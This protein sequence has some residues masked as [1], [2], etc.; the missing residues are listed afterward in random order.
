MAS[1]NECSSDDGICGDLE[2]VSGI[3][4]DDQHFHVQAKTGLADEVAPCAYPAFSPDHL[5]HASMLLTA[6]EH[7]GVDSIDKLQI[8]AGTAKQ[9]QQ[10]VLQVFPSGSAEHDA[11]TRT[12]HDAFPELTELPLAECFCELVAKAAWVRQVMR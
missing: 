1:D 12:I 3:C 10:Q 5:P 8:E 11:A 9:I 4:G 6:R 7:L 2:S